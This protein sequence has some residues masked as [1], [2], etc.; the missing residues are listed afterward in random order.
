MAGV[1]F[2]ELQ[3]RPLPVGPR[4]APRRRRG[5]RRHRRHATG[6]GSHTRRHPTSHCARLPPCAHDGRERR[7][8]RP[9]E[10]TDQQASESGKKRDHTVNNVLRVH[11]LLVIFFLSD[12][13]GG[14]VHDL[15]ITERLSGNKTFI[16]EDLRSYV[17][18]D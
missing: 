6:G 2:T 7:I 3:S 10:A 8:V 18:Q 14:R 4:P 15:R 5:G 16:T 9:H 11:A 13:H 17:W 1:R 12:T